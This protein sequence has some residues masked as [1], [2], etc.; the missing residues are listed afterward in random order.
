MELTFGRGDVDLTR[1]R[2]GQQ[3]WK[4]DDPELTRR[5][6]KSYEGDQ[7]RRRVPLD[8]VVEAAVG[9]CLRIRGRAASGAVCLAVSPDPL[10]EAEKHPLTSQVL[11]DQLGRLGGTIYELRHLEA[12][13]DGQPMVPLSVLGKLRRTMIEQLGASL[14]QPTPRSVAES[15]VI[16]SPSARQA[17]ERTW[18]CTTG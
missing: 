17:S 13:I 5:L 10:P 14:A 12:K 18:G 8:L 9:R 6:R 1:V 16:T 11:Q 7:P 4:T 2:P 3:V 15:A